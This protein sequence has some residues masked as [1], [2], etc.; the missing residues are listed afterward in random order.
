MIGKKLAL[1]TEVCGW[2]HL[3]KKQTLHSGLCVF[4]YCLRM[5]TDIIFPCCPKR[6]HVLLVIYADFISHQLMH[7]FSCAHVGTG[8]LGPELS[9]TE[10]INALV[11]LPL[12][13]STKLEFKNMPHVVHLLV[14]GVW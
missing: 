14:F 7:I 3:G 12:N 11:I 5:M 1:S 2:T 9:P 6:G 10:V 4:T 13:I 8:Q